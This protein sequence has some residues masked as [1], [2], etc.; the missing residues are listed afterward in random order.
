MTD[1]Q[2]KKFEQAIVNVCCIT[3]LAAVA[4]AA[5]VVFALASAY[6]VL[7]VWHRVF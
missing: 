7:I 6:I 4:C 3:M 1:E 2:R 5:T